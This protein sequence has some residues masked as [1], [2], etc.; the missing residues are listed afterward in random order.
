MPPH[1]S[2]RVKIVTSQNDTST[3]VPPL[4]KPQI[5]K[6]MTTEVLW[7]EPSVNLGFQKMIFVKQN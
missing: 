1:G 5:S 7:A 2:S 4:P 6:R 3:P